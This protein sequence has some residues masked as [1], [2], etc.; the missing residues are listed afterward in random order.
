M[1]DIWITRT[2]ALGDPAGAEQGWRYRG[3]SRG[4]RLNLRKMWLIRNFVVCVLC[5][6]LQLKHCQRL[7]TSAPG[8]R[9]FVYPWSSGDV[10][11]QHRC[12]QSGRWPLTYWSRFCLLASE[13]IFTIMDKKNDFKILQWWVFCSRR[14]LKFTF[15]VAQSYRTSAISEPQLFLFCRSA[16]CKKKWLQEIWFSKSTSGGATP[17]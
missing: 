6:N 2:P 5:Q 12:W 1:N 13:G 14:S 4:P 9:R 17:G 10:V 11:L 16:Q 8:K 7:N 3:D 15:F